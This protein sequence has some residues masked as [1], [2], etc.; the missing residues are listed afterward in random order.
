MNESSALAN[1]ITNPLP[2]RYLTDEPGFPGVGG[3]IKQRAEDF[4]VEELPLYEPEGSGEHL[5]LGIEKSDVAHG[6]LM[7]C[8]RRHFGVTDK[9]IGFAGMKDKAG[10]TRQTVSVHVMSEPT[11]AE[12]PHKR[13]KVLWAKRHRNKLRMGHLAGNRFSIRVRDVLPDQVEAARRTLNRLEAMGVPNYFGAQRFGY[14]HNNHL[15]G[16][17]FL[18]GDWRG[19][20]DHLLGS[21][22]AAF[23]EYQRQRR[24]LFDAGKYAEAAELWTV[25][26][27]AERIAC[28]ALGR[29]R[30]NKDACIRIG[31]NALS[32]WVSAL[33]SAIFNRVLDRR[34][35]QGLFS[36]FVEGDVAFKHDSRGMFAITTSELAGP[37]LA[38]R[39][40]MKEISPSGPLWGRGMMPAAPGSAVEAIELEALAAMGASI[41]LMT[42]GNR[43]PEGTRRPMRVML[44]NPR[45]DSGEDEHGTHLQVSFDLPRGAYATVVL[46]EIMKTDAVEAV[47][48]E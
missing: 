10:V 41:D 40:A 48:S 46:R 47:E 18:R 36:R 39:F 33:Q 29:G 9:A 3:K 23:P 1:S 31:E 8:I 38:E 28:Q 44:T 27:R 42:V 25:A 16:A 37:E 2:Q 11:T 17:A 12:I 24:E 13:I 5:Y 30:K 15:I 20:L 22:G 45:L 19:M 32:F 34:L 26:D 7:S 21:T 6:E 14:R 4:L 43:A 35:E